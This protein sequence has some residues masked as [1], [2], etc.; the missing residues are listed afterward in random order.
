MISV[1]RLSPTLVRSL[2]LGALLSGMVRSVQ[3]AEEIPGPVDAVILK[4]VDGD[5]VRV[6]ARI[7]LNQTVETLVRL[8]GIDT[9]ELKGTCPQEKDLAIQAKAL[10]ITS[11]PEGAT[12]QLTEI[13]P[14]KYGGRVVAR[15]LTPQGQDLSQVLIIA[16]LAHPYDGGRKS[17]WCP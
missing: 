3:A 16:G 2:F 8:K 10:A 1:R 14:D 9:P 15:L 5:T 4:V 6:S 13:E 11:L 17:P 7:W 12:V